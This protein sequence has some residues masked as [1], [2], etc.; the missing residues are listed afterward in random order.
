M[1]RN[2]L[3]NE[4]DMLQ[5]NIHRIMESNNAEEIGDKRCRPFLGK[6]RTAAQVAL[7]RCRILPYGKSQL[8]Y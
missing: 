3:K 1:T 5:D 7:L 4:I 2:E 6:I 8:Y